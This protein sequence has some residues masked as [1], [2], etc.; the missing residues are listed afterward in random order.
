MLRELSES[1][2]DTSENELFPIWC[3]STASERR[4]SS[5][6]LLTCWRRSLVCLFRGVSLS[7]KLMITTSV[8]VARKASMKRAFV[9][10]RG[11]V[12]IQEYRLRPAVVPAFQ[13]L[14]AT[15]MGEQCS[16]VLELSG[17]VRG[18]AELKHQA[19]CNELTMRYTP[20]FLHV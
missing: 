4:A 8:Q 9:N 13:I 12:Q 3:E 16:Q 2:T 11:Q 14:A 5:V 17:N 10:G 20:V 19:L 18:G 1:Y 7:I 6:E 15:V